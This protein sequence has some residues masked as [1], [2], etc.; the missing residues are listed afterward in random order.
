MRRTMF[1]VAV[2][3]A[4][5]FMTPSPTRAADSELPTPTL[6]TLQVPALPGIEKLQK[7]LENAPVPTLPP[8][9]QLQ[10][11]TLP[12]LQAPALQ[13]PALQMPEL[14]PLALPE[15][16]PVKLPDVSGFGIPAV[17]SVPQLTA[18]SLNRS[19][20]S[21]A[22]RPPADYSGTPRTNP[23]ELLSQL[24]ELLAVDDALPVAE[25]VD[26]AAA[27][28]LGNPF[29]ALG[30]GAGALLMLAAGGTLLRRDDG[31]AVD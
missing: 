26:P 10:T 11:P 13:A 25:L 27:N 22:A 17:P 14:Q 7:Q 21:S 16:P 18:P 6:P 2:A 29:K 28:G 8:L 15:L 9:P 5:V 12:Q 19:N 1:T 30:L 4:V 23:D 20:A 3:A 31:P 24:Q